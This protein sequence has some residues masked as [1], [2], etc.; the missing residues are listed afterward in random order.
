MWKLMG[1]MSLSYDNNDLIQLSYSLELAH[2]MR[3]QKYDMWPDVPDFLTLSKRCTQLAHLK[4]DLWV[5]KALVS[6]FYSS[7]ELVT[8]LFK[9]WYK[10]NYVWWFPGPQSSKLG[11]QWLVS[12]HLYYGR[13][14]DVKVYTIS[15]LTTGF[16]G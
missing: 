12:F 6:M 1:A 11:C 9:Y 13:I 10:K 7:N 5:N 8:L 4:L 16:M 14:P 3:Q 2:V 15:S